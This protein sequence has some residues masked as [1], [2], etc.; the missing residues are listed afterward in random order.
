ME[1]KVDEKGKSL[2]A[3]STPTPLA[4]FLMD[5]PLLWAECGPHL[6]YWEIKLGNL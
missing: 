5:N 2:P 6:P 1:T 3:T 4:C